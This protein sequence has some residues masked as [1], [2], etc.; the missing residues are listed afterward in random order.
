[1][2]RWCA[3]AVIAALAGCQSVPGPGASAVDLE[4]LSLRTAQGVVAYTVVAGP[5]PDAGWLSPDLPLPPAAVDAAQLIEDAAWM[6][7]YDFDRDDRLNAA[8]ITQAWLIGLAGWRIG[9]RPAPQALITTTRQSPLTGLTLNA[10]D[11]RRVRAALDRLTIGDAQ[12]VLQQLDRQFA[13]QAIGGDGGGG[14][15]GY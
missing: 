13:D 6:R 5:L 9:N 7:A 12:A 15:G 2:N 11:R 10:E 8:E 14:G 3:V 4:T 1:M